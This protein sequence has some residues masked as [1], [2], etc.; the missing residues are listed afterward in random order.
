MVGHRHKGGGTTNS[1]GPP[2]I[3]GQRAQEGWEGSLVGR[4]EGQAASGR[5]GG[6]AEGPVEEAGVGWLPARGG[7]DW[8]ASHSGDLL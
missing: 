4:S 1:R 5:L 3:R 7:W 2:G 8:R 6:K